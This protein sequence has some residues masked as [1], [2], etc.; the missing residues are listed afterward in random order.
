MEGRDVKKGCVLCRVLLLLR[1]V[2]PLRKEIQIK[3]VVRFPGHMR[4]RGGDLGIVDFW[5][6]CGR[7]KGWQ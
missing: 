7:G 3:V 4:E 2:V 6:D 1:E 5:V